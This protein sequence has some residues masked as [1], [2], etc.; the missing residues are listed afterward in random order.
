MR[1]FNCERNHCA[2]ILGAYKW[3]DGRRFCVED[4]DLQFDLAS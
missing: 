2:R 1:V 3:H 4:L